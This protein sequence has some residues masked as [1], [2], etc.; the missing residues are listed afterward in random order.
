MLVLPQQNI[1]GLRGEK[2]RDVGVRFPVTK[3]RNTTQLSKPGVRGESTE[4]GNR[5]GDCPSGWGPK[6]WKQKKGK[7]SV[8]GESRK[9][10]SKKKKVSKCEG[11][12]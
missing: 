6:Q 4:G 1:L 2:K 10:A 12:C 7:P 5:T 9:R 8:K 3:N 11:P